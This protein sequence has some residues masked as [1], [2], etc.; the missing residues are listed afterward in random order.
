MSRLAD[1]M[2]KLVA[3]A[4]VED[5]GLE[6]TAWGT[7]EGS[8]RVWAGREARKQIAAAFGS[9]DR[10]LAAVEAL[11]GGL[12]M[13]P[14]TRRD[15]REWIEGTAAVLHSIAEALGIAE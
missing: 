8:K 13:M 11:E 12:E 2:H 7:I 6:D 14:R 4:S 9:P 1:E 3:E 10:A 15:R 5:R